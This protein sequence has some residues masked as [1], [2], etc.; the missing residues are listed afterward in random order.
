MADHGWLHCTY[1]DDR[2]GMYE[3]IRVID[4]E[5]RAVEASPADVQT[6]HR[7]YR[8]RVLHADCALASGIPF[9]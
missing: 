3:P 6:N 8:S 5:G 2:I 4:G 7:R 1:C 9:A